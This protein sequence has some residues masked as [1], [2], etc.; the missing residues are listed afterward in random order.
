MTTL[1]ANQHPYYQQEIIPYLRE[2]YPQ[3]RTLNLSQIEVIK[4]FLLTGIGFAF[5]P[6]SAVKDEVACG[7]LMILSAEKIKD[8][9]AEIFF[10]YHVENPAAKQMQTLFSEFMVDYLSR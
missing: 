8:I 9:R 10:G 4:K 1:I 3:L 7:S 2:Q 5:L 6:Y